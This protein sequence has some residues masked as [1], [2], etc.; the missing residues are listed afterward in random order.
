MKLGLN[1]LPGLVILMPVTTQLPLSTQCRN[2]GW[3][4]HTLL[5][6]YFQRLVTRW[7]ANGGRMVGWLRFGL[8]PCYVYWFQ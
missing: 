8:Y 2:V 7:L 6:D 4:I 3:M 5:N 1:P